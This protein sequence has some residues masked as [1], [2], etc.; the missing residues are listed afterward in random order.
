MTFNR[1]E[2]FKEYIKRSQDTSQPCKDIF[3]RVVTEINKDK[4]YCK[5]QTTTGNHQDMKED[6]LYDEWWGQY[7]QDY[8]A[9]VFHA[10]L[11]TIGT[12]EDRMT[13]RINENTIYDGEFE[14]IN[15]VELMPIKDFIQTL[16]IELACKLSGNDELM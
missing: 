3:K 12:F 5:E 8:G 11:A 10:L 14:T 7:Q 16:K 2:R 4:E 13:H 1:K 6:E 9:A 15:G